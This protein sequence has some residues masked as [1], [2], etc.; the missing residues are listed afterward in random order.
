MR[1]TLPVRQDHATL[2]T[3][4]KL[5]ITWTSD[6][7]LHLWDEADGRPRGALCFFHNGTDWAFIDPSGRFDGTDGGLDEAR[8]VLDNRLVRLSQVDERYRSAGALAAVLRGE[9][10]GSR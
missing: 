7:I 4:K 3:D 6:G 2:S 5:L 1:Y 10:A 8:V 9:T